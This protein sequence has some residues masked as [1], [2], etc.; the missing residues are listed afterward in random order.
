MAGS[1]PCVHSST[2]VLIK[3]FFLTASRVLLPFAW[4]LLDCHH[5]PVQAGGNGSKNMEEASSLP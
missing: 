1:S 2:Q 3:S 4:I 5:I